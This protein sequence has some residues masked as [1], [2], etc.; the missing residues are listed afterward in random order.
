MEIP[1]SDE[2][3]GLE[4]KDVESKDPGMQIQRSSFTCRLL[5]TFLDRM[6]AADLHFVKYALHLLHGP[7]MAA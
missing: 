3:S 1:E 5:P 6:S 2:L 4:L 7:H